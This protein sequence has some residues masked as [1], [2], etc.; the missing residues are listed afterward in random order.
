MGQRLCLLPRRGWSR[1]GHQI[2]LADGCEDGGKLGRGDMD[3]QSTLGTS[4]RPQ[5]YVAQATGIRQ[6]GVPAGTCN[7]NV[8]GHG[9]LVPCWAGSGCLGCL[10]GGGMRVSYS[11]PSRRNLQ[12]GAQ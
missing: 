10:K 4:L 12:C 2:G 1:T 6:A 5:A 11:S 7:P 3:G 9:M 8:G